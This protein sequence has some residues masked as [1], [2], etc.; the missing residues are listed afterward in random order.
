MTAVNELLAAVQARL[1]GDAELATLVGG[2]IHDRRLDRIAA[3][4]LILATVET[5]DY[6]TGEAE[7]LEVLLGFEAWSK[8]GRREAEEIAGAVRAAL[9]DAGLALTTARLVGLMHQWTVSRRVAKTA[10][11]VAEVR[12]RAVLG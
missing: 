11:Y 7:G 4:C 8:T 6:S 12:M 2:E 9:H 1:M 10:M 5:R 3:P